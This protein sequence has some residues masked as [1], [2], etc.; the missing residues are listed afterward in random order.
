MKDRLRAAIAAAALLTF[1]PAFAHH[2]FAMF[3]RSRQVMLRGTVREMQWTNPHCFLQLLV[4]NEGKPVEWSLE[5]HAP[6]VMYRL[7]WRPGGFN[8]GDQVTVVIHPM[9]DGTRGGSVVSAIDASGRT[10][11]SM[12]PK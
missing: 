11:R 1:A 10:F 8:A 7:G 3:D 2:S 9:K 6:V 4:P 12:D 5:M